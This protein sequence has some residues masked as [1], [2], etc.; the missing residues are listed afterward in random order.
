MT[1]LLQ[2]E[3]EVVEEYGIDCATS[4]AVDGVLYSTVSWAKGDF[5][6]NAV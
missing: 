4:V 6:L 5:A 3:P 1:H 2:L